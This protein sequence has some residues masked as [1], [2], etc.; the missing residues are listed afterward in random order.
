MTTT[1]LRIALF[2]LAAVACSKAYIPNTDV[3][4]TGENRH[5]IEFCEQYRHALEDKNVAQLL[6]LMSPAYF[7]DGGNTRSEDDADYDKIREFLTGDFQKTGGIRYE[8]RYRRVTLTETNHIYVD[9]T[10]AAAWKIP[11]VKNDE[12]HHKV[13]D[14]RLD[15]VRAGESF[16]IVAG[17]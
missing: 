7:E 13:A 8:I 6:K 9:Y 17:M 12:W 2:A 1:Q 4:D 3:E 11:G 5:I 10:Y 15:L 16:K 14:N